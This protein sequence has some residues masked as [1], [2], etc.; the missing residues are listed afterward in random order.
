VRGFAAELA[1]AIVIMIA[2]QVCACLPT[3][4]CG[5]AGNCSGPL[6]QRHLP[7]ATTS[8]HPIP[9]PPRSTACPPHPPSA[10]LAASWAS[11]W[12]RVPR[13]ST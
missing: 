13:A 12:W 10:S 1:T 4:V 3:P 5:Q 6:I 9:A 7:A 8:A 2:S 11:A